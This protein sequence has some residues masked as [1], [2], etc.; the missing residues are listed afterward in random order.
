MLLSVDWQ[1]I[2]DFWFSSLDYLTYENETYRFSRNVG[3]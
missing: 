3:H 2:T 1:L